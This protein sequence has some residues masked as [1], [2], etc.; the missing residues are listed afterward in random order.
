MTP[1]LNIFK[2][3]SNNYMNSFYLWNNF[4]YNIPMK[5]NLLDLKKPFHCKT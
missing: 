1:L 3:E 4:K 5:N 2:V